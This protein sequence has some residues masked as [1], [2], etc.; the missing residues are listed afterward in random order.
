M[1]IAVI[2]DIHSNYPALRAVLQEIGS[3]DIDKVICAGDLVGYYSMPEE[4]IKT[5]Q[6]RDITCVQGNHDKAV[7]SE[8]PENFNISAKRATDWTRRQLSEDSLEFIRSLPTER[9]L[10]Y[11]DVSIYLTHGSPID[12]LN[13]Y[14]RKE[15][16]SEWNLNR[17][18]DEF[19]DFVLF[20]H[21]HVPF[22]K[23]IEGTIIANPGSIGQPRD[24][25]SRSSYAVINSDRKEIEF[26]RVDYNIEKIA[27]HT[28]DRLPRKIADRLFEGK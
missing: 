13:Q 21:T 27:S 18:F 8:T 19:P 3:E 10:R 24:G 12:N 2:S 28:R 1:K 20:G 22:V 6:N 17:W 16:V 4:T 14:I 7:V 15:D 23:E 5:I 9:N 11:D 25:D 26:K